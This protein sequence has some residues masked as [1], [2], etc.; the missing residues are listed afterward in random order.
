MKG[1]HFNVRFYGKT[2]EDTIKNFQIDG[3][4]D[5]AGMTT[6]T[7]DYAAISTAL[8]GRIDV[9]KKFTLEPKSVDGVKAGYLHP[10][11]VRLFDPATIKK[12]NRVWA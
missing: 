9:S 10:S 4:P 8:E 1:Y 3:P 6:K 7:W 2:A 11:G 12:R 5:E